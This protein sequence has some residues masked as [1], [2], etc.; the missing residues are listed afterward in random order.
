[1]K[2][3]TI[4]YEETAPL[5]LKQPKKS[6]DTVL[7]KKKSDTCDVLSSLQLSM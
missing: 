5:W 1:M 7:M 3:T 6:G 2:T 4:K